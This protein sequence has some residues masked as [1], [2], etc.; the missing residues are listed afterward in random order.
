M[1]KKLL[2]LFLLSVAAVVLAS[3]STTGKVPITGRSQSI[4]VS[5]EQVLSLSNQEYQKYMQSATSSADATS[6]AMVRRC[7]QRLADAV[8]AY[9]R[10]NGQNNDIAMYQ[11]EFNLVRDNSINAFCMPGGKIVVYEGLLPVT[12]DEASLSIVL[13]HEI[14]HAV[15]KHSAERMSNQLKQQ[16]SGQIL[17]Q[18]LSGS[19]MS[20][21]LQSLG[22]SVF[23]ISSQI[24]GA[25]YSRQ[26]E[27]EADRLGI[28]FA[29][30]AGYDPQVA[31]E[32][33]TRMAAATGGKTT[34]IF[35][36]HPA[37]DKR[38]GNIQKYMPEAMSYYTGRSTTSQG[39]S[40]SQSSAT[41]TNTTQPKTTKTINISTKKK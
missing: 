4:I 1:N 29:A 39:A 37:D 19:G 17:S 40:A 32:F 38:I 6:T 3:C 30:M 28:I 18:V 25:A 21:G 11:W 16:Y 2:R 13:G 41:K 22:A 7:G 5:D 23:N 20:D 35:S 27:Y 26:Q 9:L 33:W 15:A 14:A 10:Q 12:R 36:S 24:G 31:V 8:V 34:S